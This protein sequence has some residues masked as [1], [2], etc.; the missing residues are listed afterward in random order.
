MN[1]K[2][3]GTLTSA[4]FIITALIILSFIV[5][6]PMISMIILGAVFAYVIRPISNKMLPKLKFETL[7]IIIAM[8]LVI[9]PLIA[10]VAV[11]INSFIES[12][13]LIVSFAKSYNIEG[14]NSSTAQQYL[15]S[16]LQTYTGPI[17]SSIKL[18]LEEILRN[19]LNYLVSYVGSLPT[20][21][22]QLFIFFAST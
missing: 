22:F 7:S 12:V 9:I 3:K 18:G 11:I 5:L 1:Y 13:P 8:I 20:I 4:I 17:I 6:T 19:L 16:M 21:A 2:L 15:P 14:I 10:I